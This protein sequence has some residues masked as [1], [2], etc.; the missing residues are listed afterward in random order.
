MKFPF[1]PLFYA[2]KGLFEVGFIQLQCL[3]YPFIHK[4]YEIHKITPKTWYVLPCCELRLP[5]VCEIFLTDSF[6]VL[7]SHVDLPI[8]Q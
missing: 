7:L 4:D 6:L 3:L 8:D 2:V 1:H 5:N